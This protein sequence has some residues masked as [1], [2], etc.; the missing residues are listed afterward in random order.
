MKNIKKVLIIGSGPIIIGQAAEFDY[1]GTQACL[2]CREERIKTILV[3]SNPATI[4]TDHE[5][6]DTVYI[7][8]LTLPFLQKIIEKEKPDG[9]I[10]S[11]G[12]QTALNLVTELYQKGILEKN[13]VKIL[14]T[15]IS[16]IKKSEDRKIFK[17][18]MEKIKQ[19]VLPSIAINNIDQGGNFVK[20]N[21]YP[22]IIR[23][24]Y[25]LGGTGSSIAHNEK[26]FKIKADNG[27]RS[28]LIGEILLEKSVIGWAEFEYEIVRDHEGNIICVCNMENIDPMGIHTGDSIVI[29]PSQTLSDYENQLLRKA[30]FDIVKELDIQGAC[31]IQFAFN[32]KTGEYFVIEVN[33]RLSRSSALASKAT[34]YPI[35]KI[36]TKIAL[37]KTLPEIKNDITGKTAFFEPSL[38]YVVIKI[39]RWPYDKFTDLNQS[40]GITMKSTGEVMAIGRSFEEA[41]YKAIMS[42]EIKENIFNKF[43]FLSKQKI[44]SLLK[45]PN[46]QRLSAIFVAFKNG[47]SDKEINQ[48]T[49]INLWFIKN[50]RNLFQTYQDIFS[51]INVYKMVDTCSGEF[52]AITPY[53]YSTH[54]IENEANQ[55]LGP[56]V[57]ILGAGPIRIGQGIEF[58]YLTVH[59]VKALKEKGIKAIIINN[60]PETV[61]TDYSNSDRLYFEPLTPEFVLRVIENEKNGLLGVISQFGGQTAINL[62]SSLKKAGINILGTQ[63]FF[64]DLAEDRSKTAEII[65]KL[66]YKTPEWK[67]AL[68][69]EEII[70]KA[71]LL[72]YPLLI[73]PSFVIGGE[74]MII[75]KQE[76]DILNY[77]NN[78]PEIFF[79]NPVLIDKFIEGG[80]EVDIDFISDGNKVIS[81]ILEQLEPAGI[82]SGDSSCIYPTINLNKDILVK[83]KVITK[84]ISNAFN[85]I[86]L[87]NIQCAI[88]DNEIYILEINPRASRTVPFISKSI[89]ISLAKLATNVVIGDKLNN[90][91]IKGNNLLHLKS[92]VF[93]LDKLD[94]VNNKLGPLMKSTGEIMSVG[95]SLKEIYM[96][97]SNKPDFKFVQIYKL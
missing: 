63:P 27:L 57:I 38:D 18:A 62:V 40:I 70:S 75:V 85:I 59:A 34:G 8:P 26:E 74:G 52:E 89:G 60:N 47:Y 35:A 73:R 53:F 80:I 69:K 82:H 87:A 12:G 81:F 55:L 79:N 72:G 39:P 44:N 7:E 83:L 20:K 76:K 1:S 58:D 29:A 95:K 33:P 97:I 32:Q 56:K 3:N 92:P 65:K 17:E 42:L 84:K 4:Q 64:I 94:G 9:L 23:S 78:L 10:A 50:L 2:A 51:K 6:A 54:G 43:N 66:G 22:I 48:L 5:V 71:K 37:G 11:V 61:S 45:I 21:G 15:N 13:K 77:L 86:G 36:A 96:K 46:M 67:I 91:N 30:A 14:G 24:A 88:K 31:N 93:S 90:L 28:S 49:N 68:S 16:A 41:M 25:T 19:P